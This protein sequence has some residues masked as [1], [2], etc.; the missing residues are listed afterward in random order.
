MRVETTMLTSTAVMI[1]T[2]S[3]TTT[4]T[5]TKALLVLRR[6]WLCLLVLRCHTESVPM[7][8]EVR[9]DLEVRFHLLVVL[10]GQ[11]AATPER[12]FPTASTYT[13][14]IADA[15]VHRHL[16]CTSAAATAVAAAATQSIR[17]ASLF[18]VFH[19]G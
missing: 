16:I 8:Q 1:I 13:A 2:T 3:T 10:A 11:V 4:A 6:L 14:T 12:R 5:V 7:I 18:V 15:M 17:L 9:A 19:I